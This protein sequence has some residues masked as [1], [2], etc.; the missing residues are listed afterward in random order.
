VSL[1]DGSEI[2]SKLTLLD[3]K[4]DD[5]SHSSHE[6]QS[7]SRPTQLYMWSLDSEELEVD[8]SHRSAF[9]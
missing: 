9:D 3:L 4:K 1:P 2:D 8:C 5:Y 6:S 7:A